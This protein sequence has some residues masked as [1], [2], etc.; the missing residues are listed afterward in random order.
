MARTLI[1]GGTIADGNGSFKGYVIIDG[2]LIAK[3][4]KGVFSGRFDGNIID[5]ESK[6]VMPGAID[7]HVHFRDPGFTE[8]GDWTT[9]SSAAAIGGVTSVFDMPNTM[10][11]TTT[12]AQ[13]EDKAELAANKSLVNFS[14]FLGAT[15]DNLKEIRQINP[16]EVCG[17]KLF[18][19]SST[20]G[21]LVD[22]DY[23]LSALFAES[24]VVISAHCEDEASIREQTSSLK[25]LYPNA[26]AEIHSA[27]RTAEA[28]YRASARAAEL[29]DKYEARLNIAHVTTKRELSLFD[30]CN[31]MD[32]RLT[33]EVAVAHLVFCDKDYARLGN[34]I[35]C[36]PSVK[37]ADD[38]EALRKE[39]CGKIDSIVTDH[40]P[41]TT[42]QKAQP[43]WTAPSGM[44][45][46][47]HSV[48]AL[49]E[50]RHNGIVTIEQIVTAMC[51]NPAII[52]GISRRGFIREGYYADIAIIDDDSEW[53]VSRENIQYKCGW[54]PLI[55][56]TFH[57]RVVRT[58]IN[59][60]N[61]WDGERLNRDAMG[62]RLTFDR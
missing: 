25:I 14:L 9:E 46:V 47:G 38:R 60:H 34:L 16:R 62:E 24:P 61:V 57:S 27:V 6:I 53:T 12:I 35:K 45:M 37:T 13:L 22:G 40:A 58:I 8:K 42:E 51:H 52:Y 15:N 1:N 23:A 7:T 54:S 4:G 19:G 11:Q 2:N 30:N 44:P 26:T 17:V 55:D 20:G 48:A 39:I 43:Y 5:A 29:A 31:V 21:M 32:K 56:S 33:A 3:V 18:M 41:H 28:C 59:G 50:L 49:F 10:P 36:N